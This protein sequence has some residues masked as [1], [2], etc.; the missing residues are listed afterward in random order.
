MDE[1]KQEVQSE[2]SVGD[3]IKVRREKLAQLQA[4]GRDPFKLTRVLS[5]CVDFD[6]DKFDMITLNGSW[7]RERALERARLHCGKQSVD[8][9]RG[10]S[11]HQSNPFFALVSPNADED[12]GEAYGFNF[13]YSGN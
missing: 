7:A 5:M 6:S 12:M 1:R 3:Q 13:V 8:S 2:V 9:A 11:S 4:E 10:E